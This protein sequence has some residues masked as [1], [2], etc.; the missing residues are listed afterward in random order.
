MFNKYKMLK[1]EM[2][3]YA[4]YIDLFE[5]RFN[6]W[7]E[8]RDFVMN[9]GGQ[10]LPNYEHPVTLQ[11]KVL[12]LTNKYYNVG[13]MLYILE[14]KATSKFYFYEKLGSNEHIVPTYGIYNSAN[15]I[16]WDK[17]PDSFVIKTTMG[18]QAKNL[19]T[20]KNKKNF[21]PKRYKKT[22]D[23]MTH[24]L[25]DGSS[26]PIIIEK[27]LTG[28]DE[29]EHLEITDYK[30]FC[31]DG[32]PHFVRVHSKDKTSNKIGTHDKNMTFYSLP[33]FEKIPVSNNEGHR[34][35]TPDIPRPA[36]LNTMLAVARKLSAGMPYA[37]VDLYSVDGNVYVGEMTLGGAVGYVTSPL[38]YDYKWGELLKLP[39][40]TE[41]PAMIDA[42]IKFIRNMVKQHK[43]ELEK[44]TNWDKIIE[45]L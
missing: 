12:W 28:F 45:K 33:E 38:E 17:L 20:V 2:H 3:K 30:F 9:R 40:E 31:F 27:L 13:P 25:H 4:R 41:L 15:D 6:I 14:N 39:K 36:T 11:E 5:K 32:V 24:A 34:H 29:N 37:R 23:A 19:I 35:P 8:A 21:N 10:Y 1:R 44:L 42:D 7:P 16:D 43:S 22:L 18:W 26:C